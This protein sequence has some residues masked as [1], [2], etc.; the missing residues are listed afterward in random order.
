M[1]EK[2]SKSNLR[3]LIKKIG[4]IKRGFDLLD[5]HVIITDENAN[6]LYAN[7][8]VEKNTGFTINEVVGKNPADLWGGNMGADFYKKMWQVIKIE[9]KPFVGEVQNKKRDGTLY[10]QELHISPIL[11]DEGQ[12]QFF[13]GIEPNIT[14]RKEKEKFREEFISIVGHQLGNPLTT[15]SWLIETL[16]KSEKIFKKDRKILEMVYKKNKNL[17]NFVGDLLTLSRIGSAK[18]KP[19]AFDIQPEIEKIIAEVKTHNLKVK[20]SFV[21]QKNESFLVKTA[22]SLAQ[23]VFSNL[24]YNAAEYSDGKVS[25]SLKKEGNSYLFFC[26]NNGPEISEEDK[27]KIFSKFFR[28]DFARQKKIIGSGL[29]LFIVKSIADEFGWNVWFESQAGK[30]TTFFV[31]IPI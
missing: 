1:R 30:G 2:I 13:I 19:E 17:L 22:K 18:L 29:G 28:S 6:I 7:K 16:F 3:E 21:W 25:I 8:G 24:I 9:K 15:I 31:L 12:V 23:Q 14:D 26:N 27:P 10:W 11:N 20:F 5:D 4:P